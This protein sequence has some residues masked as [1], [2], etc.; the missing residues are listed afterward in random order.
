MSNDTLVQSIKEMGWRLDTLRQRQKP[1]AFCRLMWL[2]LKPNGWSTCR[3]KLHSTSFMR[4]NKAP[5]MSTSMSHIS[6]MSPTLLPR[7]Y[8]CAYLRLN[9][10]MWRICARYS[11][12]WFCSGKPE[13]RFESKSSQNAAN[14]G[15][16]I[17][18][19]IVSF[20]WRIVCRAREIFPCAVDRINRNGNNMGLEKMGESWDETSDNCE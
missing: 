18:Y 12:E 9:Y 6:A 2:L 4:E 13:C 1:S 7:P 8:R 11:R 17:T 20:I 10:A 19:L 16:V 3:E 15:P 5:R 14:S